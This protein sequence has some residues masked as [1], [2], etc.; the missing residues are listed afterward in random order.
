MKKVLLSLLFVCSITLINAQDGGVVKS[1]KTVQPK[2]MVIPRVPEGINMK[3]F[4]DSSMNIQIAIAKINEAFQKRG[5]SL[6]SFD[7]A[8]KQMKENGMLNKAAD[9]Q[10]DYKSAVLQNSGADIYVEAKLDVVL[11]SGRS[12]KSVTVILDAYQAGT[13]NSIA[14]R[15]IAGPM[16]QTDDVGKLTMLAM[17]TVSESFLNLMQLKFNDIVENGQSIYVE[18]SLSQDTKYNFD[19]EIGTQGKMLSELIEDWF[20]SHTK[21]SVYNSQG[22]T[23]N[24]FIISDARIPLKRPDNPNANYTGSN[25]FSDINKYF[26]SIGIAVKREIG[27]NNKIL[28]TIL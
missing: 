26:K 2:I 24:K 10:D 11:H 13:S 27:T 28:I 7:Q 8:L 12:A 16:N 18:F 15:T 4:Y 20:T 3:T 23:G 21:N 22:V 14:T 25:F 1:A 5:A 9:N 19:S 17:D 6:R